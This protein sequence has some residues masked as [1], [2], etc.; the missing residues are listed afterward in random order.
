M[1]Y[2]QQFLKQGDSAI[3]RFKITN[4]M[5]CLETYKDFPPMALSYHVMIVKQFGKVLKIIS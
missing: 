4:G 2:R 5:I 1:K 3:A